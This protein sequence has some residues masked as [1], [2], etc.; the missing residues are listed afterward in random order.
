M[1]SS[2]SSVCEVRPYQERDRDGLISVMNTVCAEGRWMRT[3]R[4]EPTPAWEHAL[5]NADCLCHLLLV[6]V[7]GTQVAGWCRIFPTGED[8]EAEIGVGLLAPY[9]DQ[10]LGTRMLQQAI[11]WAKDHGFTRL[12]LTTRADNG[13]ALHVF[14]RCGFRMT[15]SAKEGW[16]EMVLSFRTRS[17][18]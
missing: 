7:D 17:T 18:L 14:R 4:F 10:G 9:R 13:R 6:A 3:T 1:K 16:S 11:M 5:A 15:T 8:G 2:A 12:K